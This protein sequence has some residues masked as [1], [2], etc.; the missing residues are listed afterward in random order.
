METLR[1]RKQLEELGV[2]GTQFIL[3]KRDCRGIFYRAL[4]P[5]KTEKQ[6][7]SSSS[8]AFN[9]LIGVDSSSSGGDNNNNNTPEKRRS[10]YAATTI[11]GVGGLHVIVISIITIHHH[12]IGN[13]DINKM[14]AI[15][16]LNRSQ[17]IVMDDTNTL[18]SVNCVTPLVD[19]PVHG[20]DSTPCKELQQMYST[21]KTFA[22][23][24]V[25]RYT[26]GN[27]ARSYPTQDLLAFLLVQQ[28]SNILLLGT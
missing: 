18:P 1:R 11:P 20:V 24:L 15:E 3:P 2:G 26:G 7:S 19:H 23:S 17:D 21:N 9:R 6:S 8:S 25:T 12:H 16:E 27:M 10:K 5:R 13:A 22:G 14:V 28:H 4:L